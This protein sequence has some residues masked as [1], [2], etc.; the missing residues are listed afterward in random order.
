MCHFLPAF[1][2][3][4]VGG[5]SEQCACDCLNTNASY[6]RGRVEETFSLKYLKK[7]N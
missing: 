2:F 6:V 3:H 5:F 7:E 1:C 4:C